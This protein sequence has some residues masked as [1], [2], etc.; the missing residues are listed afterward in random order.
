MF[1]VW[2]CIECLHRILRS[3]L[4]RTK[5]TV[6]FVSSAQTEERSVKKQTNKKKTLCQNNA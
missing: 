1:T 5:M 3:E 6:K 2:I 4:L